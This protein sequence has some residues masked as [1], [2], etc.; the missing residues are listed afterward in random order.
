LRSSSVPPTRHVSLIT[1]PSGEFA[2][3]LDATCKRLLYHSQ[4]R[5]KR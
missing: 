5:K 2:N 4:Q 1:G 3:P